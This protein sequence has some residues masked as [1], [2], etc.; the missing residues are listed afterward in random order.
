MSG[1][2]A[3]IVEDESDIAA[4]MK[5]ALE[6]GAGLESEIVGTG[7]QALKAVA[8]RQPDLVLLD[9]NLPFMD[10]AEVCRI[11]RSQPATREIPIIVVSARST[12]SDRVGGLDLGADD[13]ITKPFGL[14]ELVARV[15]AVLRRTSSRS[16]S[17]ELMQYEGGDLNIDF[18]AVSVKVA[19]TPVRL[20]RREFE[21]LRVLVENRGRVLS[22]DRLL[23]RVWEANPEVEPRS[24][25]V[26][27]GRLRGKLGVAGCRIETVVGMGYRFADSGAAGT[28]GD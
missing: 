3:L 19:G 13:Y 27:V 23:E 22:R 25:D 8:E 14:R 12:E 18:E 5:H 11:L 28:P 16:G 15:R 26:H 10:G 21:L 20:T 24:V 1:P 2:R 6:R 7:S 17:K 4:L 9:L